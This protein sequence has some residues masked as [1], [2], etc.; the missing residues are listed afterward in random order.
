MIEQLDHELEAAVESQ[1]QKWLGKRLR[2]YCAFS[3]VGSVMFL[4]YEASFR[5]WT[6]QFNPGAFF[7][8]GGMWVYLL[9]ILLFWSVLGLYRRKV[10]H[11]EGLIHLSFIVITLSGLILLLA[12]PA[13]QEGAVAPL[14]QNADTPSGSRTTYLGLIVWI[15]STA[16]LFIP[17][18]PRESR[19]ALGI[20]WGM[21]ILSNLIFLRESWG[22]RIVEWILMPLAGVPG[23][24]VCS[25]VQRR[26]WDRQALSWLQGQY[27]EIKREL[28][29]AR[30]IHEMLFP[31]P[32]QQ[33]PI[34]FRYHYEPMRQI[35]G[36]Y[37]YVHRETGADGKDRAMNLI[38]IDVTGH[39]IMA[40]LTVNRIHG[41]LD[42]LF[43]ERALQP[44]EVI[45]ALNH[46]FAVTLSKH[47]I[48]ATALAVRIDSDN[49]RIEWANAG[50]PPAFVTRRDGRTERMESNA[51][52]LGVLDDAMFECSTCRADFS[53]EDRLIAYTDGAIEAADP[54]ENMLGIEGFEQMVQERRRTGPGETLLARIAENLQSYRQGPPK[55][56][57]LMVEAFLKTTVSQ[58]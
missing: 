46:Y 5:L 17:W 48:Y 25:R 11:Q 24:F 22:L 7:P 1:R 38:L 37:L 29:Q 23:F 49:R 39:G 30:A 19:K 6:S 2:N 21:A 52:M 54:G 14:I 40:A 13:L 16:S 12:F 27:G 45:T 56:D 50:H 3:M 43:G 8:L 20:L 53:A 33:D 9:N 31:R 32:Q 10:V 15:H 44:G 57:T 55:D 41:E 47:G 26:F 4:I 42:R 36:D 58:Q 28:E 34:C 18:T 35:G 51:V